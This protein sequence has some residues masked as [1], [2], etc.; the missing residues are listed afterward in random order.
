MAESGGGGNNLPEG[1]YR[2]EI[3]GAELKEDKKGGVGILFQLEVLSGEH[4]GEKQGKW[5]GLLDQ[6]GSLLDENRIK[7]VKRDLST[8]L[9]DSVDI[10]DF[11]EEAEDI[12]GDLLG[13]T[14]EITIKEKD[15]YTNVYFNS[16]AKLKSSKK[17]DVDEDEEDDDDEDEKPSKPAKRS[18]RPV[19]SDDDD[20]IRDEDEDDDD[21]DEDEEEDEEPAPKKK[22]KAKKEEADDEDEED[23]EDEVNRLLGGKKKSRR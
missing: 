6:D 2:V 10:D 11:M 12:L 18:S 17:K 22:S 14:L 20:D 13:A 15:G 9:G 7:Y 3:I 16:S 19:Q 5:L 4:E 8:L 1:K 21:A 23:A